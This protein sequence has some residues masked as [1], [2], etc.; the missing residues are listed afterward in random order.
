[1]PLLQQSH[2]GGDAQ[3]E[4]IICGDSREELKQFEDNSIDCIAT[5]PP[6]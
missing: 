1:V 4:R 5:D 3:M 2:K 6:Y